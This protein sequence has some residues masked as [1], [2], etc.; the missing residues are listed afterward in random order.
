MRLT[1][2]EFLQG[3][4]ITV[5]GFG[6]MSL[7][8]DRLVPFIHQPDDLIPGVSTWYATSCRECPA[9]C[10]MVVRNR[11]AHVVKCEGNPKHPVSRGTLCARGQAALHGLYDPDRI[12]GP[13]RK[14]NSG[15]FDSVKW[16]D[17]LDAVGKLLAKQPRIAII[18]DLQTGSLDALMRTWLGAFGSNR[19]VVYEP[20]NYE[21]VKHASGGI[22]PSFNI[23]ESDYLISFAADFL[24]TWI[25][26]IEFAHQFA[27]MREIKNGKRARFVYVGPRVSMTA[28]NADERIIVPLDAVADIAQTIASL[29]GMAT[30]APSKPIES[31]ARKYNISVD[32]THRIANR[33][34][35]AHTLVLPG[36][37]ERIAAAA[38]SINVN[39]KISMVDYSRPHAVTNIASKIEMV[40]LIADLDNGKIDILIIHGAN[41]VYALPESARFVE[42]L[43][44]V[45]TVISLSSYMDE[46]TALADFVLPSNTPLE[47]WGDYQPYPDVANLMQPTMGTLFDTRQTGDILIELARRT[48]Q[49]S[50]TIF[51]AENFYDYLRLRWGAPVSEKDDAAAAQWEAMLRIGGKWPGS[52]SAGT[53]T[54]STGYQVGFEQAPTVKAAAV[55]AKTPVVAETA[56]LPIK[57][58]DIARPEQKDEI[59]LWAYPSLYLFDGRGANRRW[60][61]E[62]PEPIVK[63]AWDSWAEINPITA[64]KLGIETNDVIEVSHNG[65][66]IR[67]SAFV[68]EGIAP[69][70][71]GIP[72]GQGHTHY[73]RYAEGIGVN[74]LPLLS[75]DNPNIK[76]RKTGEKKRITRWKGDDGQYGREIVKTAALGGMAAHREVTLPLPQGYKFNDFYPGHEHKS[77]GEKLDDYRWAMV[78]D[79][80]RCIGCHA[81]SVACY[82]E[83]NIGIVGADG[84]RR[85]REMAWLRIDRYIDWKESS[86]PILFQPMLCQHCDSAPCESVC[87]VYASY[88]TEDGLN[89]QIYNRCVG[90]RYCSNNCPY[91]VRRFNWFDYKWPEPLNYQLNPDVTVRGRGVMEKCTLCV[92]RIRQARIVAR[93]EGRRIRDGEIMPACAQTCPTGVFTFGDLKD[94]E[95]R[96][97]KLIRNDPRAYQVLHELN[98]KPAVI[99]LRRVIER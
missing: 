44:K 3:M 19:L 70:T 49:D 53:A 88:H 24:E 69:D 26:P 57:T 14:N 77:P 95:S 83:N 11:E 31:V 30:A 98:T 20:I 10:A 62:M 71:I 60:L 22:V 97:S 58:L 37:D 1:R 78:I 4:G 39:R 27:A 15:E 94:P 43:K 66:S 84:I 47:S 23:A 55:P 33:A 38:M 48:E 90:T 59:R 9:G 75:V 50:K 16:E 74:V 32:D 40:N 81:C 79:E 13:L 73:G 54:P 6:I 52:E 99:Y 42:A 25:S 56:M 29:N 85:N 18:S 7:G 8:Y 68:W 89:A 28:A 45:K 35:E 64:K 80:N 41:P 86:A 65:A 51:K 92:Q 76:V 5:S 67:V 91:K 36:T 17:A 72:M 21:K 63:G 87:P 96:V 82:A 34:A 93:R 2:R 12:K 61:Q 46:T